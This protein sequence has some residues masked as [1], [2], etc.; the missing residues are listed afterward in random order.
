MMAIRRHA[1]RRS[2]PDFAPISLEHGPIAG[3]AR[4]SNFA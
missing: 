3:R 2:K 4:R 1:M